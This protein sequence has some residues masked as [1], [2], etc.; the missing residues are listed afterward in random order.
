MGRPKASR[1]A[2]VL[3]ALPI[4]AQGAMDRSCGTTVKVR[5]IGLIAQFG[6]RIL[7]SAA[8]Q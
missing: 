4:P 5:E 3:A 8:D 7:W 1:F 2:D 6:C